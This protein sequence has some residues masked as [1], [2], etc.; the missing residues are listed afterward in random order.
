MYCAPT[1]PAKFRQAQDAGIRKRLA[2]AA[3]TGSIGPVRPTALRT[4]A[5]RDGEAGTPSIKLS[6]ETALRR[7]AVPCCAS[8]VRPVRGRPGPAQRHD[9]RTPVAA[10]SLLPSGDLERYS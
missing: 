8:L 5:A 7:V 2:K 1:T 10:W 3:Q 9:L 6:T 4:A